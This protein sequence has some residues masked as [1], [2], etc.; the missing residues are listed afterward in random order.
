MKYDV[1]YT[2]GVVQRLTLVPQAEFE[3]MRL[4]TE[5]ELEDETLAK[6]A[7][8]FKKGTSFTDK[9]PIYMSQ[10]NDGYIILPHGKFK[11]ELNLVDSE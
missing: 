7:A 2:N 6:L 5:E 3:R 4:A 9:S 1:T 8:S 11:C 10:F